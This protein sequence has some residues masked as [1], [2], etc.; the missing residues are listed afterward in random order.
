MNK[1]IGSRVEASVFKSNRSQAIRLPK[2]VAFPEGVKKVT[3]EQTEDGGLLIK[4]V[5]FSTWAD[6][7]NRPPPPEGFVEEMLRAVE[8]DP[9]PEPGP[10]F[11]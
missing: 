4:P 7:F 2:A 10:S 3:I 11:D 1:H 8:N 9:P 6:Y 5:R